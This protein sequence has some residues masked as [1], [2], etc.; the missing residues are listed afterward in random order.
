MRIGPIQ[1]GRQIFRL[2]SRVVLSTAD[3]R[4][5]GSRR[6]SCQCFISVSVNYV[7]NFVRDEEGELVI[8]WP[9][10]IHKSLMHKNVTRAIRRDEGIDRLRG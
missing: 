4:H 8:C 2:R 1:R 10:L 9:Q 6:S 7:R 5:L 3:A